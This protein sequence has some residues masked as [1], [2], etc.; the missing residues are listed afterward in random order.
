VKRVCFVLVLA[1]LLLFTVF[2]AFWNVAL[3]RGAESIIINA[4]GSVGG[5][6]KIVTADSITYTFTDNIT[7][8]I[9]VQRNN[10]VLDGVGYTLEG[11]G[12]QDDYGI[13]LIGITNVTIRNTQIVNFEVGVYLEAYSNN[14]TVIGNTLIDNHFAIELE[15]SAHN[16]ISENILI[17]NDNGIW[18]DTATSYDL[19]SNYNIV[20]GNNITLCFFDAIA[21]SN[22]SFNNT[23][24]DNNMINNGY[25]V[26]LTS[27][28]TNNTISGNNMDTSGW[29]SNSALIVT[30]T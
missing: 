11:P 9:F 3:V 25:G 7:G 6:S 1:F 24:I 20:S 4:D 8:S 10:I 14:N 30:R 29:V 26:T 18:L 28:C 5:T 27:T 2:G 13:D 22:E 16:T 21:I 12:D 17:D 23:V 15:V 19:G